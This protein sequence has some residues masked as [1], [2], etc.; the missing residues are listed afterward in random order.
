M[1]WLAR[2]YGDEDALGRSPAPVTDTDRIIAAVREQGEKTRN[3]LIVIF[4]VVPI[5]V[6]VVGGL[7]WLITARS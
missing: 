7:V 2:W 5:V 3:L 6:L 1:G 4:V